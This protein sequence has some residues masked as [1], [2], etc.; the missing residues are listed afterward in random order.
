MAV[1]GTGGG[2][3]LAVVRVPS[4]VI[5][6]LELTDLRFPV[7]ALPASPGITPPVEGLI[8]GDVLSHF[9]VE[10]NVP[11]GWMRLYEGKGLSGLCRDLPPWERVTLT[12]GGHRVELAATLNGYSVTAL[13]DSG[14]RSRIVARQAALSAGVDPAALDAEPGGITSGIGGR[15][16]VYHWHRFRTLAVG[17]ETERGPVLTVTPLGDA[18]D[19]LLG[20]DWFAQHLVWIS[21]GTSLMFAQPV[22]QR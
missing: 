5:G 9:E 1:R 8:G 3:D 10:M 19:M 18:A 20:A 22:G 2:R 13:L 11:G 4:M 17:S 7:G 6:G 12:R 15:D 14:A 16:E 21:Y